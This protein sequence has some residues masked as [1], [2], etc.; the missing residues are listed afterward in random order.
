MVITE[1]G[2]RPT[3]GCGGTT[4]PTSTVATGAYVP[5]TIL[6]AIRRGVPQVYLY[7][8]V[9]RWDDPLASTRQRTSVSS[10]T[11]SRPSGAGA[12]SCGSRARCSTAAVRTSPQHRCA[13]RSSTPRAICACWRSASATA[14]L[15]L[16][17]LADR[18]GLGSATPD[19]SP[20]GIEPARIVV[21]A[22]T[23]A[24]LVT[25]VTTGKRRRLGPG[26]EVRVQ[27]GG[28]PVVVTGLR[29]GGD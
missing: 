2:S 11:T 3:G 5:R 14:T 22:Q 23:A 7:E 29:P 17:P 15:A 6:E 16:A 20:A 13:R 8:L 28:A 10:A 19:R 1:A 25:D 26:R 24:R 9:D 27:L 4:T 21:P 12:R 18:T